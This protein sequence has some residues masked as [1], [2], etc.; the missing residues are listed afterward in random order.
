[1]DS[2]VD[3]RFRRNQKEKA[4]DFDQAHRRKGDA[5]EMR[6][7]HIFNTRSI[8]QNRDPRWRYFEHVSSARSEKTRAHRGVNMCSFIYVY[9]QIYVYCLTLCASFFSHDSLYT[10]ILRNKVAERRYD[11]IYIIALSCDII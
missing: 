8:D 2:D 4:V 1:M 7:A 10:K 3:W 6:S 11:A 9:R 5:R